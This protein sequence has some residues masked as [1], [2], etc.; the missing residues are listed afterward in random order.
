MAGCAVVCVCALSP[1]SNG[2]ELR[3]SEENVHFVSGV[4][5][6]GNSKA[7][8]SHLHQQS[9]CRRLFDRQQ[10]PGSISLNCLCVSWY[11]RQQEDLWAI[12]LSVKRIP[13]PIDFCYRVGWRFVAEFR[14]FGKMNG[15]T[16]DICWVCMAR[17]YKRMLI[18][19]IHVISNREQHN[20]FCIPLGS[21]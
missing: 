2:T 6:F 9:L 18:D 21:W 1:V 16:D 17:S 12:N 3:V 4:Y 19:S 20:P 7:N 10:I 13:T 14:R 11:E 15:V 8:K 5:F